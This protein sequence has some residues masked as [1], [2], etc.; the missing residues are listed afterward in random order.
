MRV[1]GSMAQPERDVTAADLH[2]LARFESCQ[3]TESEWTHLAHIRVAWIC[4]KLAGDNDALDR[5]RAGILR[6]NTEVLNRRHK[7]H[8]TVTTAF[9]RIVADRLE[10]GEA[11]IDFASRIDD[12]L[13]ARSPALLMYYSAE[14]LFSNEARETFVDPDLLALPAAK[15]TEA[16][17]WRSS[18]PK[19]TKPASA[20]S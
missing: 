8:E 14:K 4:L 19:K 15:N 7:Y 12:L 17:L 11:W 10:C 13:D 5:I 6:Y 20:S 3:L 2:F 16:G 1:I 9:T 18:R